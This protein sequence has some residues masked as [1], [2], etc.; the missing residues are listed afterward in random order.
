MRLLTAS[1]LITLA[2]LIVFG[3]D[4]SQTS[5]PTQKPA[6]TSEVDLELKQTANAYKR[7]DFT[8]A[9]AHAERAVLL[10]PTNKTAATFLARVRHQ[11]Y[12][13]GDGAPQNLELAQAAIEAYQRLLTLDPESE[14]AYK[15]IAVLYA[16]THQEE[17]LRSWVLQRAMNPQVS[18]QKRAEAYAVLAGKDWDC[19]YKF[20]ELPEIKSEQGKTAVVYKMTADV[21]EFQRVKQCV[22]EGLQMADAALLLDSNSEAAWSYK[23]N[24]FLE[25]AKLAEMEGSDSDKERYL[26][27][28]KEA[29]APAVRLSEERRKKEEQGQPEPNGLELVPRPL[30][31]PPTPKKPINHSED[32]N[33]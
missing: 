33:R 30:P 19:S 27:E 21:I 25:A 9:Q 23:T 32:P 28:A 15:A 31:P 3:Q 6:V 1:I 4:P 12:R 17:L 8:E 18:N 2:A 11:R 20:T 7:G 14:E 13:P 5:A 29:Q 24:L 10:D 22:T 26:K 16:V